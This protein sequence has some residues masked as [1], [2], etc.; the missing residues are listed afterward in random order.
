MANQSSDFGVTH[1]PANLV[2]I[3]MIIFKNVIFY[4]CVASFW[5]IF[6]LPLIIIIITCSTVTTKGFDVFSNL[7]MC[8]NCNLYYSVLLF[9]L[10]SF[11][12]HP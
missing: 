11:Y 6:I 1:G 2:N 9:S 5:T 8:V 10:Y 3:K 4:M 12:K 7:L